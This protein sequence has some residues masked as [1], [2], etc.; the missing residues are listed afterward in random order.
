MKICKRIDCQLP[1][2]HYDDF[3]DWSGINLSDE[4]IEKIH[5]LAEKIKPKVTLQQYM[6]ENSRTLSIRKKIK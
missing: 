5:K 6:S 3:H 2:E 4:K 1:D